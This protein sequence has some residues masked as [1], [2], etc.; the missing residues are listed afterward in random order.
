MWEDNR[1]VTFPL[2]EALWWI[3]DKSDGLKMKR[4]DEFIHAAF[5]FINW[6][7]GVLCVTRGLLWCFDSHSD[8][9]HS[10]QRIHWWAS[11]VMLNFSKS[12]LI[13]K[14][15]LHGL[16]L[17]EWKIK[18]LGRL[19]LAGNHFV[20]NQQ[21]KHFLKANPM[22]LSHYRYCCGLRVKPHLH[23]GW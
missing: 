16:R 15:I 6:L 3:M 11:D 19:L 10:L 21:G 7:T 9:T 2:E 13:K 1:G 12:V 20:V 23:Q 18:N 22:I 8:G 14:L 17:N 4:L 5:C